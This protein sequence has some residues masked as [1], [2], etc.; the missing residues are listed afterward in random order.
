MP[1]DWHTIKDTIDTTVDDTFGESVELI[2]WLS[3]RYSRGGP[4]PTRPARTTTGVFSSPGDVTLGSVATGNEMI[5]R[6]ADVDLRLSIRDTN[7]GDIR[8]GDRVR[9]V[10][11]KRAG[12]VAEITH[13]DPGNTRHVLNLSRIKEIKPNHALTPTGLVT[14]A[15]VLGTPSL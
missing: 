11:A 13:I 8:Q 7:V 10:H 3:S 15:P 5:L 1:V 14:G 9:F 4:D 6:V 12:M 2:P